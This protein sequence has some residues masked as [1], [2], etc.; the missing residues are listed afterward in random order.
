MYRVSNN[1]KNAR[2]YNDLD[3]DYDILS[4]EYKYN[5]YMFLEEN[6]NV[7]YEKLYFKI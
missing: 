2:Q 6:Y 4:S 3:L 5:I 1:M 7:F